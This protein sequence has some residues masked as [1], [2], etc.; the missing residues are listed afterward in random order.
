M[1]R[2][3]SSVTRYLEWEILSALWFYENF[4]S[5]HCLS[6]SAGVSIR[7][8]LH[9]ATGS[10]DFPRFTH[11]LNSLIKE[12]RVLRTSKGRVCLA[13]GSWG[14]VSQKQVYL[15]RGDNLRTLSQFYGTRIHMG[16]IPDSWQD[17]PVFIRDPRDIIEVLPVTEWAI[18]TPHRP[19][20]FSPELAPRPNCYT[21][22]DSSTKECQSCLLSPECR[23]ATV[24]MVSR[25]SP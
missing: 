22:F 23:T 14:A 20:D 5:Y 21:A 15:S 8:C 25:W 24:N 4:S 7:T 19:Q 17:V 16:Y 12:Q 2:G 6:T 13:L 9:P 1:P 18:L 10:G 3:K 11:T